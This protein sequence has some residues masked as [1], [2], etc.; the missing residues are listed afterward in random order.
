MRPH[1]SPLFCWDFLNCHRRFEHGGAPFLKDSLD[2][3]PVEYSFFSLRTPEAGLEFSL[4]WLAATKPPAS[5]WHP[6]EGYCAGVGRWI[7]FLPVVLLSSFRPRM[8]FLCRDGDFQIFSPSFLKLG[9]E[10]ISGLRG[11]PACAA[12]FRLRPAFS[13]RLGRA[14]SR[15][16]NFG[17]WFVNLSQFG[18]DPWSVPLFFRCNPS[19]GAVP[20]RVFLA[21]Y[22]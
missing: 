22:P 5:A 20:G 16:V 18:L 15:S 19:A 6:L 7:F 10:A 3:Q 11:R 9:V 21:F 13:P 14:E 17:D 1:Q 8:G 2:C 12:L 4:P